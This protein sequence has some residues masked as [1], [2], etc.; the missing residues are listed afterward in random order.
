MLTFCRLPHTY[1]PQ[2]PDQAK[3]AR[4]GVGIQGIWEGEKESK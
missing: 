4:T 1:P 3:C 2:L